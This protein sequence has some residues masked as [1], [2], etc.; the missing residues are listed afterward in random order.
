MLSKVI[1]N[2]LL[3]IMFIRDIEVK[4]VQ[5]LIFILSPLKN[6]LNFTCCCRT[7][8]CLNPCYN[9]HQLSVTFYQNSREWE[10]GGGIKVDSRDVQKR[11]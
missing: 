4:V 2:S 9:L 8:L 11:Q 7:M 3:L 6:K 5:N 1:S 10:E